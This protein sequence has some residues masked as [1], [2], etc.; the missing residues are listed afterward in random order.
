LDVAR[1][2]RNARQLGDARMK[3][4]QPSGSCQTAGR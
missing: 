2:L 1:Q 3:C 4:C